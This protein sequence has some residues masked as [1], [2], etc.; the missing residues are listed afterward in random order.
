MRR[1]RYPFSLIGLSGVLLLMILSRVPSI[2]AAQVLTV[3]VADPNSLY[4]QVGTP[5]NVQFTATGGAVG[6]TYTYNLVT[7]TEPSGTQ[8]FGNVG[9][10]TDAPDPGSEGSYTLGIQAKDDAGN[11]SPVTNFTVCV[12]IAISPSTPR[13]PDITA[14]VPYGPV[15]ISS[16]CGKGTVTYGLSGAPNGITLT[17]NGDGTAT[18]SGT[19]TVFNA[20]STPYTL[21][22]TATDSSTPSRTSTRSYDVNLLYPE[23]KFTPAK[24]LGTKD[25]QF[26]PAT[27]VFSNRPSPLT[28]TVLTGAGQTSLPSGMD[29]IAIT[30][31][32][33]TLKGTPKTA[34]SY[35]VVVEVSDANNIKTTVTVPF[36][37]SGPVLS[38][39]PLTLP[40]PNATVNT[41]YSQAFTVS[42]GVAPYFITMT[43]NA[44]SGLSL[45]PAGGISADGTF[46]I[47]GTPKAAGS[48]PITITARDSSTPP[49][50]LG[51]GGAQVYNLSVTD[52]ASP[53]YGSV[54]PVGSTISFGLVGTPG[55]EVSQALVI[56][57]SG[58]ATLK[59]CTPDIPCSPI[60][61]GTNASDFRFTGAVIP[62]FT[63]PAG[64]FSATLVIAC[65]PSSTLF[66]STATMTLRT[67]DPLR[68]TVTYQLSCN[69][70]IPTATPGIGT[71]TAISGTAMPSVEVLGRSTAI[72][73]DAPDT[74]ATLTF[75]KGLALRSGPYLGATMLGVLKRDKA[76][77]VLAL[78]SGDGEGKFNWYLVVDE[79]NK[80]IG[81]AS[82]RYLILKGDPNIPYTPTIFDQI[83]NAPDVKARL[84]IFGNVNIRARPSDRMPVIHTTVYGTELQ[85]I[86]RTQQA[87]VTQWVQVRYFD[88][89][90]RTIVGWV[91]YNFNAPELMKLTGIAPLDAVPLR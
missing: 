64:G 89:T 82:G 66:A 37:V 33:F 19:A 27:V 28:V 48:Y 50:Q 4:G 38:I 91:Y 55:T 22:V 54:P 59:V 34:G 31:N 72:V 71:P 2:L 60:F 74:F 36:I 67:N 43:V 47:D 14:T 25:V 17:N 42:G 75:V 8:F 68:T 86:G 90:G 13:L 26:G 23:L 87:G 51:N 40:Q 1:W 5:F 21:T 81:W 10:L 49:R 39:S 32:G 53:I 41:P 76:Y 56:T 46:S 52:G 24:L 69:T 11:T 73:T 30:S 20:N 78:N 80:R 79:D 18:I 15:T 7:G 9:Q 3:G 84:T 65:K 88:E 45:V 29:P 35:Q 6:A 62:P 57:N 61:S 44:N 16:T 77:P 58:A 85:I 83:D 12:G 70:I 63:V